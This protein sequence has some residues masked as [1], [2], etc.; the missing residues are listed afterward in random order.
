MYQITS[1][2]A[3]SCSRA[4]PR[5]ATRES[6][7]DGVSEPELSALRREMLSMAM[8]LTRTRADA[9][10]AVQSAFLRGVESRLGPGVMWSA[11]LRVVTRRLIIDDVRT[12]RRRHLL[13]T[14]YAESGG[15]A[16]ELDDPAPAASPEQ[17]RRE[18]ESCSAHL[19]EILELYYDQQL[20]HKDIAVRLCISPK[21][22]ATRLHR[23]R[24]QLR[25][26][27]AKRAR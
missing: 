4:E 7:G 21:T 3:G 27:I 22:V 18:I 15:C 12:R 19:R 25:D 11:W 23:A 13:L 1:L 5:A 8:R 6:L 24:A 26:K 14:S 2:A 20:S 10:D 16:A 9:E 17:L